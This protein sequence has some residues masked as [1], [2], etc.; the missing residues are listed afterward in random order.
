MIKRWKN[1]KKQ[2]IWGEVQSFWGKI[3]Y[4]LVILC[5]FYDVAIIEPNTS[6]HR[7]ILAI[8]VV[9]SFVLVI[10]CVIWISLPGRGEKWNAMDENIPQQSEEIG[11]VRGNMN[12]LKELELSEKSKKQR[13][14]TQYHLYKL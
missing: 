13:H 11:C 2:R 6:S 9:L 1:S 5:I 12:D 10:W 8:F 7:L 4:Y 14:I 3:Q